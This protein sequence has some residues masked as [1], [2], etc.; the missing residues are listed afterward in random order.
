MRELRRGLDTLVRRGEIVATLD[1]DGD[2]IYRDQRQATD[3]H[4]QNQLSVEEVRR[5]RRNPT[6]NHLIS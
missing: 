6:K 3:V 2:V 4:R 1:D 5:L